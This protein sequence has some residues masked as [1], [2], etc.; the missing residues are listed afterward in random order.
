MIALLTENLKS[1]QTRKFRKIYLHLLN[2]LHFNVQIREVSVRSI[3]KVNHI[4]LHIYK[5]KI[6]CRSVE[7][8]V[9]NNMLYLHAK[10][11]GI[12]P[13]PVIYEL[14]DIDTLCIYFSNLR[15]SIN[16]R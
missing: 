14:S 10:T 11:W 13:S 3:T 5:N 8:G 7:V 2:V 4:E 6:L 16:I 15:V 9:V 1:K 12:Q